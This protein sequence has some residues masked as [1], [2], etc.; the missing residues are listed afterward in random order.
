VARPRPRR[1]GW[2]LIGGLVALAVVVVGGTWLYIHVIEG[3]A[4]APLSL[5][6]APAS[7]PAASSS[8]PAT[9]GPPSSDTVT[10]TWHVA[11]GSVVGYR[12]N[13]VLAD[14][15]RTVY[16]QYGLEKAFLDRKST[17]LNSSHH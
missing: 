7:T 9:A 6:S 8:P 13:E 14:P 10:G 1:V 16:H 12:V 17:R 15:Q 11:A 2:W 4:P 3:P 5:K